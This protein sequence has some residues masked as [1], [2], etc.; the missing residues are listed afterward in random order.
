MISLLLLLNYFLIIC[1]SFVV[2]NSIKRSQLSVKKD[3]NNFNFKESIFETVDTLIQLP[4][5]VTS[6]INDTQRKTT[7]LVEETENSLNTAQ[8]SIEN[9]VNA[10]IRLVNNGIKFLK[11]LRPSNIQI[12]EIERGMVD[13]AKIIA[14]NKIMEEEEMTSGWD[15]LKDMVY[16][17][18]DLLE[19]V[20][21]TVQEM[22]ENLQSIPKKVQKIQDTMS[23]IYKGSMNNLKSSQMFVSNIQKSVGSVGEK[24]KNTANTVTQFTKKGNSE[25]EGNTKKKLT[26]EKIEVSS[27]KKSLNIPRVS[28]PTI[29]APFDQ[30]KGT[31]QLEKTAES[32]TKVLV[33]SQKIGGAV[34]TVVSSGLDIVAFSMDATQKALK[35]AEEVKKDDKN[36][37]PVVV[38][39]SD[40]VWRE[41]GSIDFATE[42]EKGL[43]KVK[44]PIPAVAVVPAVP[45]KDDKKIAL[46]EVKEP[47]PAVAEVPVV[48]AKDDK[49]IA[50]KEVK[51]SIPAVAEVPV[52]PVKPKVDSNDGKE[53]V[54]KN[55]STSPQIKNNTKPGQ[56][57]V[58]RNYSISSPI[59]NKTKQ[60]TEVTAVSA[61]KNDN[62]SS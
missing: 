56:E 2:L 41:K 51:E 52:V 12:N 36:S 33:A 22:S 34:V 48:P 47:I 11:S 46:K 42:E 3:D 23:D 8:K 49:K 1:N 21:D 61:K 28:V 10:P 24:S 4:E 14:Q 30:K 27:R 16:S 62:S 5:K 44:E 60:N 39:D 7:V 55:Y 40:G 32:T 20:A 58:R 19:N 59:K 35:A 50:L 26:K 43:E 18:V 57:K 29:K 6:T 31:K 53:K 9:S 25:E 15:R 13:P 17:A 54:S 37:A 45:A 38:L